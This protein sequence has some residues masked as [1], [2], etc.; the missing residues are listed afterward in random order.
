MQIIAKL[1][2]IKSMY[3]VS[4]KIIQIFTIFYNLGLKNL[5]DSDH[6]INLFTIKMR[7]NIFLKILKCLKIQLQIIIN[8]KKI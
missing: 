3:K 6:F 4:N 2:Q 1:L 7:N 8:M 5:W